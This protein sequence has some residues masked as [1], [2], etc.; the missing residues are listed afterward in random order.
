MHDNQQPIDGSVAESVIGDDAPE[1]DTQ[2]VVDRPD[3]VP[4][5]FWDADRG[6]IKADM[7]L[8]SYVELE[9]RL[10]KSLPMPSEDDPES[11]Q[12]VLAALGRPESPEGYEL[13]EAVAGIVADPELNTLLHGA[14]F[15]QAQANLVYQLAS[16]RLNPLLDEMNAEIAAAEQRV[17]LEHHFGGAE[18]YEMVASDLKRWGENRFGVEALETIASSYDGVLALHQMMNSSEPEMVGGSGE[19]P[20]PVTAEQLNEMVADPRYWR[21]HDPA[22]IARVTEGFAKLFPD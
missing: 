2:P 16:E 9:K 8:Q 6:E 15:T 22:F 17:R 21:D 19:G 4:E 3:G 11:M 10:G 7:L 18:R 14:G 5:K 13:S 12:R 20:S 1:I